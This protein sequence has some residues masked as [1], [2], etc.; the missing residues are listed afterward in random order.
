MFDCCDK[1]VN[2]N[3]IANYVLLKPCIFAKN[4]AY[5]YIRKNPRLATSQKVQFA[6]ANIFEWSDCINDQHQRTQTGQNHKNE[7]L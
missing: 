2:C 4:G 5:L 1:I 3:I 6:V 7:L